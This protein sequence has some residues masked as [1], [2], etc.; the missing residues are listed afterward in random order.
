MR[1]GDNLIDYTYTSYF[2]L[3]RICV[4]DMRN[5]ILKSMSPSIAVSGNA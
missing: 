1:L 5:N 3:N 2:R 4:N